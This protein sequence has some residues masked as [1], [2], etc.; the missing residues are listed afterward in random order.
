MQLAE[1]AAAASAAQ[2]LVYQAGTQQ[3]AASCSS[4]HLEGRYVPTDIPST[5]ID[6]HSN[7][8]SL[9]FCQGPTNRYSMVGLPYPMVECPRSVTDFFL[10]ESMHLISLENGG[11]SAVNQATL[12][13]LQLTKDRLDGTVLYGGW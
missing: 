12:F 11:T 9:P 13:G 3:A 1:L 5:A 4:S 8:G 2:L 6:C 10:K 7:F